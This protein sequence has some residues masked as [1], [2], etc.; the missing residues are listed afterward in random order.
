EEGT[1][2]GGYFTSFVI[3]PA[4]SFAPSWNGMAK[5]VAFLVNQHSVLLPIIFALQSVGDGLIVA[6]GPV[7]EESIA[8][9][10]TGL[11][12]GEG[13]HAVVR[14]MELAHSG[15]LHFDAQLPAATSRSS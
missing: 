10:Q 4:E 8:S 12:L 11:G 9:N 13:W 7:T 5:R 1:T 6:E 15:G 14:T 3:E 2:S